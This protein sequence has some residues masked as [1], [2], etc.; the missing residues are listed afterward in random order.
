MIKYKKTASDI[1]FRVFLIIFMTLV[2]LVTIYPLWY[3]LIGSFN[4]GLDF[5][6]GGV[7]LFPRKFTWENY[8]VVFDNQDLIKGFIVTVARTVIGSVTHTLFTATFAY[9]F[10]QKKLRLK[11]AYFGLCVFTMFVNGGLIPTYIVIT[12]LGF[13]DNILVYFI[14]TLFSFWDGLILMNF[15]RGIPE[16]LYESARLEGAGEY[17]IFYSIV[18]PLSV[19]GL[20][21]ILMFSLVGH[22]NSYF[23]S[24]LYM[25]RNTDLRTL[26]HIIMNM[27]KSKKNINSG[28]LLPDSQVTSDAIQFA[29]MVVAT[30]PIIV[31]FP[32]LQKYFI[33]GVLVGSVKE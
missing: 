17:R 14:P 33:A 7:Y 28:V 21:A 23:D 27:I 5:L 8:A 15:F 16:S 10:M 2:V 22:W 30:L 25:V 11:K 1:I 12:M 4:E 32:F 19:P 3:I 18:I 29:S 9:G 24:M 6:R 31:A 26:Q 20:A 13:T